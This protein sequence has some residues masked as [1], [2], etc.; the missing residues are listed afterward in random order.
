MPNVKQFLQ[1]FIDAGAIST[2]IVQ[3]SARTVTLEIVMTREQWEAMDKDIDGEL[4]AIERHGTRG[5]NELW[6]YTVLLFK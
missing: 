1:M 3:E 2:R 4:R 6:L 5:N